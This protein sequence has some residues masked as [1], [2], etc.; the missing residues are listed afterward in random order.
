MS[1]EPNQNG[2]Y[3]QNDPYSYQDGSRDQQGYAQPDNSLPLRKYT[4]EAGNGQGR[5]QEM[6]ANQEVNII[7]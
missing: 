2:Q 1:N 5:Q 6:Y 7:E 4:N 3:E